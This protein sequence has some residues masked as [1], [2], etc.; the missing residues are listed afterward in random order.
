MQQL[1]ATNKQWIDWPI[2]AFEIS[3][4]LRDLKMGNP[5][6]SD[7]LLPEWYKVFCKKLKPFFVELFDEIVETEKLH[8]LARCGLLTLIEKLGKDCLEI[9]NWRPISLLCAD[10]KILAKVIVNRL[11][12]VMPKLIHNSQTGFMK[13]RNVG[14]N[15]LKMQAILDYCENNDKIRY[16]HMF[17]F[18]QSLWYSW[19]WSHFCY[20]WKNLILGL[21]L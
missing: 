7:G 12:K 20:S 16:Y 18:P 21:N 9:D 6:G 19:V 11:Q 3:A 4:A 8:L 17:W 2:E 10:Y 13:G 14:M 5:L 15:I 1:D